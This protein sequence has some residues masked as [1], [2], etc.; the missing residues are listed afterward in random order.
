M[1][2][3]LSLC[4]EIDQVAGALKSD[5][6]EV[7]G[8]VSLPYPAF[9]PAQLGF[10]RTV[11]WLYVLYNEAGKINISFLSNKLSVYDLDPLGTLSNHLQIV[12]QLRT[13][14]QHNLD[15]TKT[16]NRSIQECCRNW[17]KRQCKTP[18]PGNEEQW[19]ASLLGLLNEAVGFLVAIRDCV[20]RIEQDESKE[21]ILRDWDFRRRRYHPPHEFD[22]LT[23]IVASDMGR[24]N[25]DPVRIRIRFYSKWVGELSLLQG[26]YDFDIE[27]RKLIEHVLLFE[28]TPVLPL[29]G[30]DIIDL[31][32]V[33]PGPQVGLLLKEAHLLYSTNPCSREVL[34]EKLKL[35]VE[36]KAS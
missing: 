18:I 24:D 17:L 21:E 19:N 28:T 11:S 1:Y 12:Q 31:L 2:K 3:V 23:S 15:P 27:A 14:L 9:S 20:R 6:P 22:R 7:F 26:D 32:N 8:Q 25:L 36:S 33:E 13:Y 34:I 10:I 29:T 16:Q 30:K 4:E 5:G 35:I